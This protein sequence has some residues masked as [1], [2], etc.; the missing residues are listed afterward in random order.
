M[1]KRRIQIFMIFAVLLGIAAVIFFAPFFNISNVYITRSDIDSEYKVSDEEVIEASGIVMGKNIFATDISKVKDAILSIPYVS[2]AAV[3]RVFP[4]KIKITLT[5][6]VYAASVQC[7]N[8]YALIDTDGKILELVESVED[9]GVPMLL[10]FDIVDAE[11]GETI[12]S[13]GNPIFAAALKVLKALSDNGLLSSA[14]SI[15]TSDLNSIEILIG[16]RARILVSEDSDLDYKM[17]FIKKVMDERL[18]PYESMTL[19]FRADDLSARSYDAPEPTAS[20]ESN[21]DKAENASAP[22][23]AATSAT[24]TAAATASATATASAGKIETEDNED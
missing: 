18:S 4:N 10:G 17:R 5:E 13:D 12:P 9:S 19:D 8:A 11:A 15:D 14:R 7:E 24:A 21:E 6:A 2:D 20:A 23:S 22:A 1:I 3:R 16:D